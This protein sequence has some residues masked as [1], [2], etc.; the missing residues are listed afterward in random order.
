MTPKTVHIVD[1]GL[2]N[3][4]SIKNACL[5]V[6]L[7][8]II[9]SRADDFKQADIVILPGVGAFGDAM[10]SLKSMDLV[11]PIKSVARSGKPLVGICLGMQLLMTESNEFGIH[12][13][14]DIIP[15]ITSRLKTTS[16][17]HGNRIKV[18]H[19]GWNRIVEPDNRYNEQRL[20]NTSE[21]LWD[22]TPMDSIQEGE[23]MYFVHSYYVTPDDSSIIL[24]NTTYGENTFCSA[25]RMNNIFAVQ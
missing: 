4:F 23:Y 22:N 25:L 8:P 9:S 18:P 19:I 2:G 16:D 7:T 5:K 6:G 21:T 24:S 17:F 3:L 11:E 12:K 13:G 15:G 10:A 1:Y 14:L 20:E